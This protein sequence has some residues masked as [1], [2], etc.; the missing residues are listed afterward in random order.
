MTF[1]VENHCK[2]ATP[3]IK[4][5]SNGTFHVIYLKYCKN[6]KKKWENNSPHFST[7]KLVLGHNFAICY[8][9]FSMNMLPINAKYF[10]R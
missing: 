3:K 8:N 5:N 10:S 7:I 1:L 9:C 4:K 2:F 6:F